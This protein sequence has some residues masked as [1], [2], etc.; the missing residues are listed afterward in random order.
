[1]SKINQIEK[2]ILSLEGGAFQNLCDSYLHKKRGLENINPLGILV[3]TNK[4]RMGTPDTFSRLPNGKYIFVESTLQQTGLFDKL[5]EDLGKCFDDAKTGIQ[6]S[7]IQEIILCFGSVLKPSEEQILQ[8]KCNA[9]GI[10]LSL[11]GIGTIAYDLYNKF[12]RLAKDHLGIE[13]DSG[14]IVEI[15][16]FVNAYG[17]NK[18]ASSLDTS[19]HFR[20]EELNKLLEVL[21]DAALVIV[22][23]QPGVG[24]SRLALEAC[25]NFAINHP[26]YKVYSILNRAQD[27]FTDL[28]DYFSDAGNYLIFVDDANRISNFAYFVDLLQ[29]KRQDQIIKIVATVRGYAAEKIRDISKA[30]GGFAEIEINTFSDD[31]IKKLVED[32]LNVKNNVYLERIAE[33][34]KGNSRIAMMTAEIAVKANRLDS[35]NDVSNLYDEYFSSIHQDVDVL[36]DSSVLKAAGILAFYRGID[37]LNEQQML[38]I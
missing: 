11:F 16:D 32:E 4:V 14:Q 33:I 15:D 20:E 37:R 27:L 26:D 36:G 29:R 31:Q 25:R 6:T 28:R 12:P 13:I 8:E 3:G 5:D 23:G 10:V 22:S 17:K 38:A 1:M 21:D 9:Y 24:K 7:D 34:A 18:F 2:E 30:Y 35:I 19:F